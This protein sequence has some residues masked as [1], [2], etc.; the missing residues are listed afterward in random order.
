MVVCLFISSFSFALFL[1]SVSVPVCASACRFLCVLSDL[2]ERGQEQYVSRCV[3]L[4]CVFCLFQLISHGAPASRL[5]FL[6]HPSLK[7]TLTESEMSKCARGS[8]KRR[9]G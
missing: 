1:Y 2:M 5:P 8:R 7:W 3:C 4:L 9:E 6:Q